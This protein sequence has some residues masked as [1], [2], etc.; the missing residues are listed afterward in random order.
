MLNEG[1]SPALREGLVASGQVL[2]A[3]MADKA[4]GAQL[5]TPSVS[6]GAENLYMRGPLEEA[7]R[8]NLACVR[9]WPAHS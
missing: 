8:G 7:T 6:Y 9:Y 3:L 5:V 2:D 1:A 4:L